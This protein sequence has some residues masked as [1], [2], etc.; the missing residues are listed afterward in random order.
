MNH[1][2]PSQSAILNPPSA[3]P[4][5][6]TLCPKIRVLDAAK[7]LVEYVAS[8]ETI[9]SY[10]EIIRAD[11]WRFNRFAKNAPFV[12]SH[13]YSS[14]DKLLGKVVD[15][16]VEGRQLIETVEWAINAGLPENHLANIGWKMTVAGY[17][18]GVSVGFMPLDWISAW[19]KDKADG[20]EAW[21]QQLVD[22]QLPADTNVRTIYLEQDQH[23]LS[24]VIIG[25]NPDA[26]ARSYKAGAL[27]DGQLETLSLWSAKRETASRATDPDTARLAQCRAHEQALQRILNAV[28]TL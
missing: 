10:R 14:V 9:D 27:N 23:E 20:K 22:L 18:K 2:S 5:I 24:A 17:L 4:L 13:D 3:L 21:E 25:A 1:R 15:F 12:D 28:N 16:R 11:G 8:N 26:V 7:G 6:R 19:D